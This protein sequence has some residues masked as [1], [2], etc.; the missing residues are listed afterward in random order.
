M[1]SKV[2]ELR[3][4]VLTS[5]LHQAFQ[6][7]CGRRVGQSN[8]LVLLLLRLVPE[9]MMW[10]RGYASDDRPPPLSRSLTKWLD[11]HSPC[12]DHYHQHRARSHRP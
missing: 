12:T 5:I 8:C 6:L 1:V 4:F 2:R 10:T 9:N 3:I 11:S 7:T